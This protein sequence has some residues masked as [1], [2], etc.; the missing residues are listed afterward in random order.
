MLGF[1]AI[2]MSLSLGDPKAYQSSMNTM[3]FAGVG[4]L[5][6]LGA[7]TIFFILNKTLGLGLAWTTP[8]EIYTFFI[9]E[10]R[11]LLIGMG[12]QNP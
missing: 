1:G 7:F 9:G 12:I 8:E 10:L 2:K 5:I 4:A 6:V 3:L 11:G